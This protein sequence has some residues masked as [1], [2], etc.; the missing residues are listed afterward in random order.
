MLALL[1]E[2]GLGFVPPS[3]CSTASTASSSPHTTTASEASADSTSDFGSLLDEGSL[4]GIG[5]LENVRTNSSL[6]H[7]CEV[8]STQD[9]SVGAWGVILTCVGVFDLQNT[10]RKSKM[11]NQ[12]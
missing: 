6:C 3:L 2:A 10:K 9:V 8:A 7:C 5:Y 11:S 4:D 12:I 1:E